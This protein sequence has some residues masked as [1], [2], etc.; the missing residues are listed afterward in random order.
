MGQRANSHFAH[1][2]QSFFSIYQ[3]PISFV[4]YPRSENTYHDEKAGELEGIGFRLLRGKPPTL[5]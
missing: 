3:F 4:T 2:L 5:R 1:G